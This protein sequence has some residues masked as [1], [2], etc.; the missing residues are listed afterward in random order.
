[1]SLL[2]HLLPQ[3]LIVTLA[4]GQD[5]L[6]QFYTASDG[7]AKAAHDQFCLG[8]HFAN[9]PYDGDKSYMS[10]LDSGSD[11]SRANCFK[12]RICDVL[13][14]VSKNAESTDWNFFMKSNYTAK[15]FDYIF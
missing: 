2:F 1:M 13:L 5:V 10:A 7:C 11:L 9:S 4:S 8:L 12:G 15:L 14:Y 6:S 3:L